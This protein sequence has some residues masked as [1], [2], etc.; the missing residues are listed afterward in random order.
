MQ[1]CLNASKVFRAEVAVSFSVKVIGDG[2]G[3]GVGKLRIFVDDGIPFPVTIMPGS[4]FATLSTVTVAE[5]DV[6]V[7]QA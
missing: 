6:K 7:A 3:D 5:P 1:T 2:V 4:R